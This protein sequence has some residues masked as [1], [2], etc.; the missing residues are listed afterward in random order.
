MPGICAWGIHEGQNRP[1]KFRRQLHHAQRFAI[2][3]RLGLT[4]IADHALLGVASL[5]LADY[6]HR[7]ALEFRQAGNQRSVV[8]KRTIAVQFDKIGKQQR[9]VVGQI[10]AQRMPR[11]LGALPWTEVRIKFLA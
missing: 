9:D 5:L 4:K 10:R 7:S 6:R 2:T 11:N 3:F 8:S 1:A